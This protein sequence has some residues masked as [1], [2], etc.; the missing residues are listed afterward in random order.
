M[1]N[2]IDIQKKI[3]SPLGKLIIS[4]MASSVCLSNDY[5]ANEIKSNPE[6]FKEFSIHFNKYRYQL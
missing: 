6:L 4:K 2:I 3:N 5:M 1:E